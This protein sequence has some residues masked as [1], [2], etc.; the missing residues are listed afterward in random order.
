ME[1][2]RRYVDRVGARLDIRAAAVAGS[3]ARVDFNL[4]SDVDV[5]IVAEGLPTSAPDRVGLLL[6]GAPARV[7]PIGYSPDEFERERV[8]R[9][10]LVAE[11]IE[12]GIVLHGAEVL[13]APARGQ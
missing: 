12:R 3:V 7:Q 10:P 8:R 13:R 2:A 9:N 11:V 6:E 1:L 5:V 4:W